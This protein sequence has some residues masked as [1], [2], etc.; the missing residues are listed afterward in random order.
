M[1]FELLFT[2]ITQRI[3]SRAKVRVLSKSVIIYTLWLVICIRCGCFLNTSVRDTEA[4]RAG[5]THASLIK[6]STPKRFNC[7]YNWVCA[8][9]PWL[10]WISPFDIKQANY[11]VSCILTQGCLCAKKLALHISK[12]SHSRNFRNVRQCPFSLTPSLSV[13]FFNA[14]SFNDELSGVN[15]L[16]NSSRI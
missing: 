16:T 14:L 10:L 9:L 13:A 2:V 6:F 1:Q 4:T 3:I 11:S 5:Q 15:V 12:Y 8:L 7:F